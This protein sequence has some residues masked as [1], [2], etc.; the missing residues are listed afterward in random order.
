LQGR[1]ASRSPPVAEQLPGAATPPPAA[2]ELLTYQALLAGLQALLAEDD[3][4]ALTI[5]AA[6][7]F[8]ALLRQSD[9]PGDP[10]LQRLRRYA[11]QLLHQIRAEL[12]LHEQL[13]VP[14]LLVETTN[15]S[16]APMNDA[17]DVSTS[18]H[19]CV[20]YRLAAFTIVPFPV[21]AVYTGRHS[22]NML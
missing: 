6:P 15:T 3:A 8:I 14:P 5:A 12:T 22:P 19:V 21:T 16:S 20:D 7:A 10:N 17:S 2:V 1:V 13:V 11:V 4:G 9:H 18:T